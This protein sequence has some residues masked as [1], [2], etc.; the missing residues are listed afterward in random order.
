MKNRLLIILLASFATATQAAALAPAQQQAQAANLAAQILSRHHYKALPLDDA[1]SQ[2]IFDRYLKTL[3]PER[4]FFLQSD[5]A[6]FS[7]SRTR[8][9]DAIL[10]EDLRIPFDIFNLFQ[11]RV[12]ERLA[13]ARELLKQDFD[14]TG[15]ESFQYQRDKEP[16]PA[17]QDEMQDLWRKRVKNDW[18]RLKLAGKDDKFIRTTLDKRYANNVARAEKYKS[19]DVFQLFLDSYATAI[20]PH[21]DYMGPSASADFDIAMSLSLVGIGAVLQ[22]RDDYTTIRDLVPGG[23]A[24]LSTK[25]KVGDRIV[26]VGQGAEGAMTD[27]VG[28]RV[29]DVVGLIRGAKDTTVRLDILPVDAGPDAKHKRVALVRN[30]I[31]LDR[32]AAQKTVIQVKDGASTRPVGVITLPMFYQDIEARRRGDKE[33]KSAARDVERLLEQLKKDRIDSVLIDLRNNGGGSLDEAIELTSLFT[34]V[35]PVLQERNS[36]GDIKVDS[37]RTIKATWSGTVGVLINRGSASASEIFAAAIQDYGRGVIIGEP[38]F[39][40]GTVQTVVSLDQV[41]HNEKPQFGELKMT[42]AQFF[43]INGGTTQLRGV[44]PDIRFPTVSDTDQFGE[45]SY[46]NALPW[47]QIK[48]ANFMPVGDL[49]RLVPLLEDRHASRIAKDKDFQYLLEDLREVQQ[50]RARRQLSL[51]ES[52]RRRER[53]EREARLK[54]RETTGMEADAAKGGRL[55]KQA[56]AARKIVPQDAGLQAGERSLSEELAEEKAQKEAK[57]IWLEEAARI[58]GDEAS[59][60]KSEPRLAARS[61]PASVPTAG[62]KR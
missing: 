45:S 39:G 41:A 17:S 47:T 21:T 10:Q 24:A 59:L 6:Q 7:A 51:N 20:D 35:G 1:M 25:L 60:R 8:L 55:N 43:R 48:A 23:P 22:V 57:D 56:A 26:A 11:Q 3:D 58:V 37:A 18:L 50:Q 49:S 19:E 34:G 29:N 61:T 16:W 30:K 12:T 40:K 54:Q 31:S 28:W 2:K 53:D 42:I 33:F 15:N 27:I 9:D 14:F 5:I 4:L 36:R 38:S 62:L 13:Y 52:E 46:D 44:V 32:Q